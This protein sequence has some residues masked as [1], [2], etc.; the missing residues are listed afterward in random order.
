MVSSPLGEGPGF[1]SEQAGQCRRVER[2]STSR[3]FM[4]E[5]HELL[6]RA[7][8]GRD[9]RC[10]VVSFFVANLLPQDLWR[11]TKQKKAT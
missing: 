9:E 10:H 3:L 6:E 1:S 11:G 8:H 7:R 5:A 2:D 4:Q